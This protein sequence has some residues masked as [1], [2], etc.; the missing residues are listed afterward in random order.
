MKVLLDI[1]D[2][3]KA[4]ALLEVLRDLSF[5]NQITILTESEDPFSQVWDNEEDAIYD[6]I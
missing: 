6:N 1:K 4:H 3:K 2:E 5:V